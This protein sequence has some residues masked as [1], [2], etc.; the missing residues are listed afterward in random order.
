MLI[1]LVNIVDKYS[2]MENI[3]LFVIIFFCRNGKY[4]IILIVFNF[5]FLLFIIGK[6]WINMVID[7][8]MYK[9]NIKY[10]L[11]NSYYIYKCLCV[12]K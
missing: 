1:F 9:R 12:C 11:I 3:V 6:I 10:R 4:L 8:Y 7:M 2:C 5:F